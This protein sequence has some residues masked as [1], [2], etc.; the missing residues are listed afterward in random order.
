VILLAVAQS[1]E[2]AARSGR[3]RAHH[4]VR[5][6]TADVARYSNAGGQ[7]SPSPAP[8]PDQCR[9]SSG[10]V[11]SADPRH[12]RAPRI[13]VVTKPGPTVGRDRASQFVQKR[14]CRDCQLA[15]R[16]RQ[17]PASSCRLL[18]LEETLEPGA[19]FATFSLRSPLSDRRP[20]TAI[21]RIHRSGTEPSRRTQPRDSPRALPARLCAAPPMASVS[22]SPWS[23]A[24][25][26]QR[27]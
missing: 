10:G 25:C 20:T 21:P 16:G 19:W 7:R 13:P 22:L 8:P 27:R 9:P 14:E 23:G 12:R 5:R 11:P 17:A 26:V 4:S 1:G 24:R 2:R 15:P 18:R 6:L 3:R